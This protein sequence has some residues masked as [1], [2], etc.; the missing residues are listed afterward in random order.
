ME[1]LLIIIANTNA[2]NVKKDGSIF[3]DRGASGAVFLG[4]YVEGRRI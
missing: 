1:D 2:E 4:V 3:Y